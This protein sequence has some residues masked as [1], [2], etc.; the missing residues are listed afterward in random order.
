MILSLQTEAAVS[1]HEDSMARIVVIAGKGK[2]ELEFY[3]YTYVKGKGKNE[4]IVWLL[5]E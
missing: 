4:L 3:R 2:K 5:P 1:S